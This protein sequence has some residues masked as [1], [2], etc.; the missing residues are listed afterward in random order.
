[1]WFLFELV[2]GLKPRTTYNV[3]EV[4]FNT[5]RILLAAANNDGCMDTV[6]ATIV[7]GG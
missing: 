7:A 6:L 1:M 3:V 4:T 2:L 5:N